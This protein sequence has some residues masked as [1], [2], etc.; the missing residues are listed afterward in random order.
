MLEDIDQGVSYLRGLKQS[1]DLHEGTAPAPARATTPEKHPRLET[2]DANS[3]ERFPGPEKRRSARYRCEGSAG[4]RE[5]GRDVQTW[6][7]FTDISLHG[8]YVEAQATYPVGTVLHLKLE[9]NGVR[10]EN[11]G[12][13]RVSYPYLGMGIAFTEV[14]EETRGHMKEMMGSLSRPTAT[15]GL[16]IGGF[17]IASSLPAQGPL[18][19]L[20]KIADPAAAIQA[21][22]EFFDNRQMLMREDFLRILRKSQDQGAK[23]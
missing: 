3:G 19:V 9:A 2:T 12:T 13:V 8:C 11:T 7:R 4:M 20:P 14:S 10:V 23:K 1:L 15:T 21:L 16:G 5:D 6:A 17:E 22:A 18:H